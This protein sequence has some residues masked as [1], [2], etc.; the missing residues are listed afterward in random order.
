MMREP[1][2][3]GASRRSQK[4]AGVARTDQSQALT[5]DAAAIAAVRQAF[6]DAGYCDTGVREAIGDD[7]VKFVAQRR[8]EPVLRSTAGGSPIETFIRLFGLGAAVEPSVARRAFGPL[9]V[10]GWAD[11]GLVVPAADGIRS[12]V[13]VSPVHHQGPSWLVVHD[14]QAGRLASD[15]VVGVGAASLALAALTVRSPV[16]RSLDLGT[17]SGIQALY[18][19]SHSRQVV[20]TDRE[21][22]AVAFARFNLALNGL[23]DVDCRVGDRFEPVAGE[24]F[25]LVVSNPPF[26]ISPARELSYRDSG[27]AVDELCRSIARQGAEHLSR[28]GYLQMMASWPHVTGE[29]WED[30]IHGW[31]D[32][33]GCDTWVI[34]RQV[35]TPA[36]YAMSWLGHG[37]AGEPGSLA[38]RLATWMDHYSS[39]GIEAFGYGLVTMRRV[40]DRAPWF[41]A[42]AMV[43]DV[44]VPAG[45]A[46]ALG[47]ELA[48]WLLSRP[49]DEALLDAHLAVPEGVRLD[50]RYGVDNAD[51]TA[52]T[53]LL[54]QV[55]GLRLRGMIDFDA[56]R[57]LALCDGSRPLRSVLAGL[58]DD[59]GAG[60]VRIAPQALRAIRE[61]IGQGF[62]V[63]V[64]LAER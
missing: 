35:D 41:R 38:A 37:G 27:L 29:R 48:E 60:P 50:V 51:W 49:G 5:T 46:I 45:S 26:V 33:C 56:A 22:R 32:G 53:I 54:Q 31:V 57:A 3:T 15:L 2:C 34:E 44:A 8:P 11:A 55:D 40:D 42:D 18:L 9:G 25:D 61:L 10:E 30:R 19:A 4:G 13:E 47:F 21:A 12:V 23:P 28:R 36:A 58:A 64:D 63:P 43:Q 52:E 16:P 20:A 6:D 59:Q 62:L 17:G 7:G 14:S 1:A 24:R 39:Q